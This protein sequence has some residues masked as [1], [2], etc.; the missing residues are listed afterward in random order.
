M[1]IAVSGTHG[2][3]KSTLIADFL[4]AHPEFVHEPEPYELMADEFPAEPD[5][6]DFQRQLEFS[7]ERWRTCEPETP[8]IGERSPLDFLA[9]L[10]ALGDLGRDGEA[11]SFIEPAIELVRSGFEHIDLFILLSLNEDDGIVIAEEEDLELRDAMNERLTNILAKNEFEFF[12]G[13]QPVFAEVSGT[14]AERL[15]RLEIACINALAQWDYTAARTGERTWLLIGS[16]N[17]SYYHNVEI[18]LRGVTF[19]DLPEE[20]SHAEFTLRRSFDDALAIDVSAEPKDDIG[21]HHYEIHASELLVRYGTVYYYERENLKPG[22][23]I[24]PWVKTKR[25]P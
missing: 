23:K 12:A 9:Y 5:A 7:V 14:P 13:G 16:F 4:A 21:M 19:C 10:L 15:Q 1:R 22:E 18:E 20:F 11:S 24:A 17:F 25:R 8:V 3:G 2:S 6:S